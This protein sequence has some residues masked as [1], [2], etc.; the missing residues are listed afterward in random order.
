MKM[1]NKNLDAGWKG[2]LENPLQKNRL[3]AITS[4]L[5]IEKE[6]GKHVFPAPQ[7][8][9]AAFQYTPF[10]NIKVVIL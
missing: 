2:I 3:Q 4:I 1:I 6:A 10:H 7:D 9:F 8:I 5:K